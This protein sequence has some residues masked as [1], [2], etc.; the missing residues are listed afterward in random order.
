MFAPLPPEDVAAERLSP[1]AKLSH[2]QVLSQIVPQCDN[3]TN[4]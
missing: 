1:R 4:P 3:R 2:A